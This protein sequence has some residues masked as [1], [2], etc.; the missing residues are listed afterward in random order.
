MQDG[1]PGD[2]P[3]SERLRML[4]SYQQAWRTLSWTAKESATLVG[5]M[6]ELVG[7]VLGLAAHGNA[8]V[9][10][11]IPSLFRGIPGRE[12]RFESPN[13]CRDFTMDPSQDLLVTLE[14]S[15]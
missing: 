2:L 11:Q 13:P 15:E 1:P 6:W 14:V 3:S 10:R 8:I 5:D 9:F 4:R 12:W 7:G